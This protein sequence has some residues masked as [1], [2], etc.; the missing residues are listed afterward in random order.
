MHVNQSL[1]LITN[2]ISFHY[3]HSMSGSQNQVTNNPICCERNND[4][5]IIII[6][7]ITIIITITY[8][9]RVNPISWSCYKWVPLATRKLT[10]KGKNNFLTY[11]D[12]HFYHMQDVHVLHVPHV[13]KTFVRHNRTLSNLHSC[14]YV[15]Y[16]VLLRV[17]EKWHENTANFFRDSPSLIFL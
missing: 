4:L 12:L 1:M 13:V 16:N 14:E 5:I 6:I 10:S 15:M 9:T 17:I 11:A 3:R 2:I 8:L 7:I